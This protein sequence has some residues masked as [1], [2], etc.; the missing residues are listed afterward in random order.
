MKDEGKSK[1]KLFET[2]ARL[3]YRNGYRAIGVDTI[4]AESGI[5][6]MTLY[7]HYSSKDEL[8]SAYLQNSNERFWSQF[9]QITAVASTPRRKLLA[10]FEALQEYATSPSC[11]GCPFLNVATEYPES[12]YS[13]HRLAFE[14]KKSV[15]ARFRE[16][17]LQAGAHDPD[18]LAD[19]LYLLMDGAYMSA[20]L[21][22][23]SPENPAGRLS[24]AARA[25]VDAQCQTRAHRG[26]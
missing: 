11:H 16:L 20:R 3:F 25:L 7:R 22:G 8:I 13:G 6:K 12:G 18:Q 19:A 9:E 14:H 26:V 15:H 21:F 10:F 23:P 5:G 4:A 24:N 17:S 2:A 1:R